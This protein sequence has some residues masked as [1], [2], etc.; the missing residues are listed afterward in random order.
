MSDI[1]LTPEQGTFAAENH[2]LVLKFL[3][4]NHLPEDEFYDVVIFGYLKAVKKF[5]SRPDMCQYSFSTMAW[6]EMRGALSNHLRTQGRKMRT[7]DVISI[8]SGLYAGGLPLEHS[9]P[10]G[11]DVMAELE[12]QLLLHELAGM[13]TKEQMQ[14]V[15]MRSDGY[16]IR[17]IAKSHNVT[18]KCVR[19]VLDIACSALKQLCNDYE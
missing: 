6:K 14:M 16:D 18:M 3:N 2:G 11:H 9:V 10:Y 12:T 4:E 1:P 5:F 13:I 15:R 7:A 8:H 19:H 17:E